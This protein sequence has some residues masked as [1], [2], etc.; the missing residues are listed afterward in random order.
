LQTILGIKQGPAIRL[1]VALNPATM[2]VQNQKGHHALASLW[3]WGMLA[4][5]AEMALIL[6][7]S[8]ILQYTHQSS[9]PKTIE[10]T[11]L[12]TAHTRVQ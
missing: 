7:F 6:Q 9:L 1:N 11:P 12:A 4:Y 2:R 5:M 3:Q 8:W 10:D